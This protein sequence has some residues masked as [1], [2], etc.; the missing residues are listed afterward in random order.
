[1]G[2]EVCLEIFRKQ[3]QLEIKLQIAVQKVRKT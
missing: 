2:Y 3:P 1:M